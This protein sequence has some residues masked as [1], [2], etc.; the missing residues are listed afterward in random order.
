MEISTT[1]TVPETEYKL[2]LTNIRVDFRRERLTYSVTVVDPSTGK[3]AKNHGLPTVF[4][5]DGDDFTTQVAPRLRGS[6]NL[7]AGIRTH[8]KNQLPATAGD[9][10]DLD[11]DD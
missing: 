5:V 8:C 4:R 7:L 3:P 10:T 6:G 1:V 2:V 9:V 11:T